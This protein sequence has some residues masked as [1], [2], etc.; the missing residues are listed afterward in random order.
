MPPRVRRGETQYVD[1]VE[2]EDKYVGAG[3]WQKHDSKS[4]RFFFVHGEHGSTQW[5]P[6]PGIDVEILHQPPPE[7][8]STVEIPVG[9]VPYPHVDRARHMKMK[10]AGFYLVDGECNVCKKGFEL[11]DGKCT[12][13]AH[14]SR[15]AHAGPCNRRL[16]AR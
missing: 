12:A 14:E 5:H 8:I 15:S 10:D 2:F 6:P 11:I 7:L 1:T 4:K 3:W 16:M 13:R 9:E